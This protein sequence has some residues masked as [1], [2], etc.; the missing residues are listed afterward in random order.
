M[1]K[2][3]LLFL[4]CVYASIGAWANV[5]YPYSFGT[6]SSVDYDSTTGMMTVN[7]ATTGDFQTF[8]DKLAWSGEG[9]FNLNKT[10]N[11]RINCTNNATISSSEVTNLKTA[12]SNNAFVYLDLTNAA[13][14]ADATITSFI[15]NGVTYVALPQGKD[16]SNITLKDDGTIKGV[17]TSN[18]SS[19]TY[20]AYNGAGDSNFSKVLTGSSLQSVGSWTITNGATSG[21]IAAGNE[22]NAILETIIGNS[23]A[24]TLSVTCDGLS[25]NANITLK[26]SSSI[27]N[28]TLSGIKNFSDSWQ[29]VTIDG[30]GTS[31]NSTLTTLTIENSEIPNGATINNF[32]ELTTADLRGMKL[33]QNKRV[34]LTDDPKLASL[35]LYKSSSDTQHLFNGTTNTSGTTVNVTYALP[36]IPIEYHD[37]QVT[38]NLSARSGA[39]M[40]DLITEAETE[41][42][43]SSTNI[44]TLKVTGELSTTD[45]ESL[46]DANTATR[47]DLSEA[48]LATG[49]AI[50]SLQVPST[51]ESLVLPPNQTVK[52]TTL[53][54][55]LSTTNCPNL[56]YAY[57]PTSD[58]GATVPDYIWVNQGD[59]LNAAYKAETPLLTSIYIK[60]AANDNTLTATDMDMRN[61]N[62]LGESGGL[63]NLAFLDLSEAGLTPAISATYKCPDK[64]GYTGYR[65]I[66]P[67]NRTGDQMAIYA[68]NPNVGSIAAVYSYT[69]TELNILEIND[70]SY[71]R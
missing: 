11:L 39:T 10:N 28:L 16:I 19:A 34:T 52:G 48:T 4:M 42:A 15:A 62:I 20:T 59:G 8:V 40:S 21:K 1:K 50:T 3:L 24:S 66:L 65:I 25:Q 23:T 44:C 9:T 26:P 33:T 71:S 60:V 49:A 31:D 38:I 2:Y 67:N 68:A 22:A 64:N 18:G 55:T 29:T 41:L 54:N 56:L 37:C 70:G 32:A 69:G 57:S 14:D 36:A 63:S 51:L 45:L 35:I 61:A 13:F 53:A 17:V 12:K 47:I 6:G 46:D 30:S 7:I 27:T 58:A 5:T 43:K